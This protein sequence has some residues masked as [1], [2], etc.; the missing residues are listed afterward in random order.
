[1]FEAFSVFAAPVTLRILGRVVEFK[2][3][4][5]GQARAGND[6]LQ[7]VNA[8]PQGVVYGGLMDLALTL[9]G[10]AWREALASHGLVAGRRN[11]RLS[12]PVTI[13]V[14]E[15]AHKAT[16]ALVSR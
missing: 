9:Q 10:P 7:V 16:M 14:G 15:A 4:S 5:K 13:T 6:E 12:V 2:P 1:V 3:D 8:S 11:Q